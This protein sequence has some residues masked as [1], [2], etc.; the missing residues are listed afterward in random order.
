MISPDLLA[1]MQQRSMTIAILFEIRKNNGV[2]VRATNHDKDLYWNG[3]RYNHKI[4]FQSSNIEKTT[5]L[6]TDNASVQLGLYSDLVTLNEV[7]NGVFINAPFRI[8][9]VNWQ[10]IDDGAF[11]IH[12][13]T[14]GSITYDSNNNFIDI[15]TSGESNK[16]INSKIRKITKTCNAEFGDFRCGIKLFPWDTWENG[17]IYI[18]GDRVNRGAVETDIP[19]TN[20]A[21]SS[22]GVV[23]SKDLISGWTFASDCNYSTVDD[24]GTIVLKGDTFNEGNLG[25]VYQTVTTL[26]V[27]N[28][29]DSVK[30]TITARTL[31]VVKS[32]RLRL[33]ITL[34][35]SAGEEIGY[36]ESDWF[37]LRNIDDVYGLGT[38]LLP[39][40]TAIQVGFALRSNDGLLTAHVKDAKLKKIDGASP[41]VQY[42]L[43]KI[44]PLD[45]PEVLSSQT[46]KLQARAD[47]QITL[48]NPN[49]SFDG[50]QSFDI[51]S[52]TGWDNTEYMATIDT[53]LGL[54]PSAGDRFLICED[55]TVTPCDEKV[56]QSFYIQDKDKIIIEVTS[57][58]P[59]GDSA[60]KLDL[61][62]EFYDDTV[63]VINTQTFDA[64]PTTSGSLFTFTKM[65]DRV[66]DATIAKITLNFK[67]TTSQCFIA[68]D[69]VKVSQY[70]LSYGTEFDPVESVSITP[71]ETVFDV[72]SEPLF[73]SAQSQLFA[74]Y[75]TVQSNAL[76]STNRFK[77]SNFTGLSIEDM[78]N[79][80]VIALS[81]PNT[82]QALR[83]L[84]IDTVNDLIEFSGNFLYTPNVGDNYYITYGCN[85]QITTCVA[86]NNPINF[87]GVPFLPTEDELKDLFTQVP[88]TVEET[89]QEELI[90]PLP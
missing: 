8:I 68:V 35:N 86:R 53:Y 64:T 59:S 23:A 60:S 58:L 11:I 52:I 38:F 71:P 36:K 88:I 82:G 69:E 2:W 34:L 90:P 10:N 67:S 37:L 19:L 73:W 18:V 78:Y 39:G 25:Y 41:L 3:R 83:I 81:G 63:T 76:N 4:P 26:P 61:I 16:V 20:N 32:E 70:A 12:S 45:A 27:F 47:A 21:F 9:L 75:S 77:L 42:K 65:V 22:D 51:D 40:T 56:K 44:F 1:H 87:R 14:V 33:D 84:A 48:L 7:E 30:F 43:E 85:K 5:D 28:P 89:T 55:T 74:F 79:G 50:T 15:K 13:G 72:S 17:K 80:F 54:N 57:L 62:I 46:Q 49:F 66:T 31:D 29:K 24:N 6:T